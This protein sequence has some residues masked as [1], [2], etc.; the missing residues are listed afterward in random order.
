M[1]RTWV[2]GGE[3]GRRGFLGG[4]LSKSRKRALAWAFGPCLVIAVSIPT[5]GIVIALACYAVLFVATAD[6]HRGSLAERI[7]RNRRQR[8]AAREGW[9]GYVPYSQEQW[10]ALAARSRKDAKGARREAVQM[11]QFPDGADGMGWLELRPGRAGIAWHAPAGEEQYLS[12]AFSVDGQIRGIET[13]AALE[14]AAVAFGTLQASM[15]SHLSLA[16]RLQT[17]TRVIPPE[18]ARHEAWVRDNLD[19]GAPA[20]LAH[21]YEQVLRKMRGA[22]HQRHFIVVCWPLTDRFYAAAGRHGKGRDGWRALMATEIRSIERRLRAAKYRKVKALSAHQLAAVIRHMQSPSIAIDRARDADPLNFGLAAPQIE[23]SAHVVEG[24]DDAGRPVQW[25]HR[26]AAITGGNML[27]SQR[28][29]LW[30]LPILT[31]L[32]HQIVRTVSINRLII[33]ASIAKRVAR[34]DVTADESERMAK[35]EAGNDDDGTKVR[36]SAAKARKYDLRPNSGHH[37]AEWI[38]HITISARSRDE[39]ALAVDLITEACDTGL[40]VERLEW[41]DTMQPAASGCTWPIGRGL[42]SHRD[43]LGDRAINVLAGTGAKD[44]L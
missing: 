35:A 1:S 33:P 30:I 12:V 37:G 40:G 19:P 2:L 21:S 4:G 11:R 10:D 31:Q 17:V 25:W 18:L 15:G 5:W 9:G 27:T 8:A 6:T 22:M 3:S 34:K 14:R 41:L 20:K 24:H 28:T 39:L 36:L 7:T 26:T 23:R 32:P 44:S 29:P 13:D 16:K 43:S 42:R 38:G